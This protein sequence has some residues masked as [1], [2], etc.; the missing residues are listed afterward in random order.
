MLP[1]A[2]KTWFFG[3]PWLKEKTTS[4]IFPHNGGPN[5][6]QGMRASPP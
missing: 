5:A 3:K 4:T 6:F 1:V 2:S